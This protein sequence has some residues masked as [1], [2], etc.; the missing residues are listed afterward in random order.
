MA[1]LPRN[2]VPGLAQ[3]VIQRG[4][5][6][7]A[8]FFVDG[9]YRLYLDALHEAATHY[10]CAIHAYVLMTNHVHLLLT[11]R[12]E[13]GL[14]RMMQSVGRRYVRYINSIYRRSGTLWEGRF[15]SAVIDSER[16][17]LTCMRYIELNPVRAGMADSPD[18]YR[19]SSFRSNARGVP[20]KLIT[21]HALY[22]ALGSSDTECRRTYRSLFEACI[23][24][25]ALDRIRTATQSG[26]VIGNQGFRE[27]IARALKRRV[28]KLP[29]GG[30]RKSAAFRSQRIQKL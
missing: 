7:Q 29:H 17:L 14:S 1:R 10:D 30:D 19:W 12:M 27:Q 23:D 6:R 18:G 26:G 15:K 8:V 13:G 4:N 20:C 3:H 22:R 2:L 21:P 24:P 28:E 11:P 25:D 16:Y 9:D 5:N